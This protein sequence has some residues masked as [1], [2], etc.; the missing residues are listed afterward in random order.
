MNKIMYYLARGKSN[1]RKLK[2]S[3]KDDFVEEVVEKKESWPVLLQAIE[4]AKTLNRPLQIVNVGRLGRSPT[5]LQ[6]LRDSGV[7]FDTDGVLCDRNVAQH[8]AFAQEWVQH[9]TNTMRD[10]SQK[11]TTFPHR[12]DVRCVRGALKGSKNAAKMRSERSR[13][14]YAVI[15]KVIESLR[16]EGVTWDEITDRLNREG[17]R[18][19]S[20][21]LLNRPTVIRLYQRA[22]K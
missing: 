21:C 4:R 22:R 13:R 20:G 7:K 12:N 1:L 6:P 9:L 11:R 5:F 18:S 2:R 14:A 17:H 10:V 3:V 19:T 16:T 15:V 8:Y